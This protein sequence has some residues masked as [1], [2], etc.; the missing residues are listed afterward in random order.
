M[1][2]YHG[3]RLALTTFTVAPLRPGRIDR[4]TASAAMNLAPLVG[5]LLGLALGGLLTALRTVGAPPLLA[6][7]LTVVAATLLTRAIHLDGLADTTDGLGCYGGPERGLAV[8][9]ASDIGPFGVSAIVLVVAVQS[10]ALTVLSGWA[11]VAAYTVGRLAATWTCRRGVPAARPEGMGALVA[12]TVPPW[13]LAAGTVVV[14]AGTAP[15]VPERLWQGPL[16][17]A[18][19]LTVGVL[20]VRHAVRRFGGVTGDVIGAAIEITATVTMVGLAIEGRGGG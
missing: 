12:G 1:N 17:A 15:V 16:A 3:F 18:T 4:P 13:A 19:A 9:K 8:M 6:A 7:V 11:V 20:L 2:W 5:A 10:A 14:V